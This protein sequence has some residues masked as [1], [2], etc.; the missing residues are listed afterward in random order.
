MRK[1]DS[2]VK[3]A[4]FVF[5]LLLNESSEAILFFVSCAHGFQTRINEFFN[6]FVLY[7]FFFNL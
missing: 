1:I 2:E 4:F 3:I 6:E 5:F 7:L